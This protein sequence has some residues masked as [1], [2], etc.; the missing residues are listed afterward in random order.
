LCLQFVGLG[1]GSL[2]WYSGTSPTWLLL[3]H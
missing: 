1:C 2:H 3:C